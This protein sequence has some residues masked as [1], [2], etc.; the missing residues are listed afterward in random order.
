E[1]ASVR[2]AAETAHELPVE[3]GAE[4]TRIHRTI[5]ADGEPAAVMEDVVHP[6]VPLPPRA[7][8]RAALQRGDMVLDVLVGQGVPIAFANTRILPRLLTP[9][10]PGAVA[11]GVAE[12]TATLEL[13]AT[14]HLT[15]G[16]T[17]LRSRDLFAPE[18]I[19]LHVMRWLDVRR[20][21]QIA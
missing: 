9:P 3:E 16:A 2:L 7:R 10:E 18:R 6:D 21:A 14:Y 13:E 15:T 4:A 12:P 1:V 17:V 8:L 11:L 5:L 19:D 20:P